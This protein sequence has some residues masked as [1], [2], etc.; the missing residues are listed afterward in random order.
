MPLF[1]QKDMASAVAIADMVTLT[2]LFPS[3]IVLIGLSGLFNICPT[4]QALCDFIS[5]KCLRRSLL[6]DIKDVSEPEKRLKRTSV[7]PIL[8]A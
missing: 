2:R 7:P 4:S 1:P 3:K 6:M 5:A 8:Q